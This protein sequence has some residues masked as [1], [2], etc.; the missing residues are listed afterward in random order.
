MEIIQ[1]SISILFRNKVDIRKKQLIEL[2]MFF[3][4]NS[5]YGEWSKRGEVDNVEKN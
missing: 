3:E 4:K 5:N 2:K 1:S